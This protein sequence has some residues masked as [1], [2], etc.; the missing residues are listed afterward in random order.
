MAFAAISMTAIIAI[1]AFVID[2]GSW[3]Q[4]DRKAQSAADAGALA[5]AQY[6]PGSPST[7]ISTA[8]TYVSKNITGATATITT[9]YN[10]DANQIHVTVQ[11]SAPTYFAKI[12]GMN[13]VQVSAG[14][15]ASGAKGPIG[16]GYWV[17]PMAVS[18]SCGGDGTQPCVGTYSGYNYIAYHHLGSCTGSTYSFCFTQLNSA[19]AWK[20]SAANDATLRGWIL[21]GY[22]T[23]LSIG[24][25]TGDYQTTDCSS[26]CTNTSGNECGHNAT[27]A[28]CT[29]AAALVA[30]AGEEIL[31][32]VFDPTKTKSLN[33]FYIRGFAL[34]KIASTNVF[35]N[36][37]DAAHWW[38]TGQY[39]GNVT[40]QNPGQGGGTPPGYGSNCY[41]DPQNP[42]ISGSDYGVSGGA[43]QLTQ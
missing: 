32:P 12:F 26:P 2:V 28:S 33:H 11:A 36:S 29:L 30:M 34:F 9:P 10:G 7:A 6:L 4:T 3:Y 13:S 27:P 42:P 1:A 16:T 22:P 20:E 40:C 41:G 24:A 8:Q 31:V 35:Q 19:A 5:A 14:S 15:T 38:I 18:G 17:V 43:I 25:N 37:Q 21:G 23:P 39:L